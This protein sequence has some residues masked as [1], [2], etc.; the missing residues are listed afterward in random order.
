ME[1]YRKYFGLSSYVEGEDHRAREPENCGLTAFHMPNEVSTQD[2]VY[3]HIELSEEAPQKDISPRPSVCVPGLVIS[4][5][6]AQGS[7]SFPFL[8]P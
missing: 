5:G 3:Y 2:N 8:L 6:L 1:A 7:G 4:A